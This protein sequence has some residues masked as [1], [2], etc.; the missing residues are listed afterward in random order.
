[1]SQPIVS[2]TQL[3]IV[4]SHFEETL[5]FYQ[6]LG[7]EFALTTDPPP[8]ALHAHATVGAVQ[9]EIDNQYLAR[10]YNAG[11][12]RESVTHPIIWI[13]L[14]DRQQVDATYTKLVAAGFEPRQPPYDAFWGSRYAIVADPEGNDVGLMSP[15]D[16]QHRSWPP[17]KSPDR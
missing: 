14:G 5:R 12:G 13:T 1:M 10:M 2:I 15:V 17:S 11:A 9:L 8:G 7:V 16:E 4:A 6:T 3:N